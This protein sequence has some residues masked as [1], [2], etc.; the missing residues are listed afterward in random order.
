MKVGVI[1]EADRMM[2]A[3]ENAFLKTLEEPPE[4][5][6]LIMITAYPEQLLDTILSRCIRVTLRLEKAREYSERELVLIDAPGKVPFRQT[7]PVAR[8]RPDGA[9][10]CPVQ[11]DEG[12][13][14]QGAHT[15]AFK[16]ESDQY[17]KTTGGRLAE[18]TR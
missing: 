15:A 17:Q 10:L 4:G 8:P 3:A 14:W 16:R 18:E 6:L 1:D 11:G 5:C 13:D 9:V 12:G 2:E 7:Q